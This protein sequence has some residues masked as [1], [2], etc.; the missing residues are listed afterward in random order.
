ME[1]VKA[2]FMREQPLGRVTKSEANFFKT[3]LKCPP[4]SPKWFN[5]RRMKRLVE[6]YFIGL[7]R[8]ASFL[9]FSF[10]AFL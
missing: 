4:R 10:Y 3:A 5:A 8:L 9:K 7:I 1:S 6:L 2:P